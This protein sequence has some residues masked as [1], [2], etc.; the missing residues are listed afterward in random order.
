M[1]QLF[2]IATISPG[3]LQPSIA[4]AT[5]RAGELALLDFEYI[6]DPHTVAK[7]VQHLTGAF[8]IKLSGAS[9]KAL[10]WLVTGAPERLKTV[11][12]TSD[13]PQD[14]RDPVRLLREKGITTLLEAR[15][16]EEARNGEAIGVDGIIAKGHE[17]GGR[18]AD[19]T[20]FVL[21]QRF[22]AEVSL[23]VWAHGGIGL[24]TG[25]ACAMAGAAGII[26]DVQ[27]ALTRESP[28]SEQV[29]ARIRSMDGSETL[30][31]GEQLGETYRVY[32]RPGN[33]AVKQLQ[34]I[35]A[36]LSNDPRSAQ[37]I[38]ADWRQ[39]VLELAGWESEQNALMLGQDAAFAAS[40]AKRFHTVGG[41]LRAM[42]DAIESHCH[43]ADRLRPLA[44]GAPLARSHGTRYP[45]LQGP[46]TRVSDVPEFGARVA[47]EGGLPFLA[48]ALMRGPEIKS[49]LERAKDR[50][51]S[52][53]WGVG[54]LGFVPPELRQEQLDVIRDYP[55]PFALIA[56]GRPDQ[57]RA[58]EQQGIT[59]YLH[60]PS[61]GLLQ[62]FV[63]QGARRFV[64]EGRECGGHVG[65]RTS[66]VLWNQMVDVLLDAPELAAEP[67]SFHVVFA[68]GIHDA[69]SAAMVSVIAAPLAERGVRIGA[70]LGT[71]YLFTE[72]AVA[73][74]AIMKTFQ[75]QARQCHRT[76]LLETGPGHSTRCVDTPYA[77]AFTEE[78]KRLST[79]G[80][81]ADEVRMA[82][83][84]L[85]LGRLRIA[86]KGLT[87]HPGFAQ[88]G[89]GPK[90]IE[91]GENEQV[92]Q[93]MY[94][95][96][97][98]AALRQEVCTIQE[99]HRSVAV[100][101]SNKLQGLADR[102]WQAP[103]AVRRAE[104][105][106]SIAIIGMSCLL[107][108]APDLLTYWD[109]ILHKVD[110][111]G[112]I[113]KGRW[114]WELYFDSDPKAKDKI[115][116]KWGGF[117]EDVAFD[118]T[119]Y[120]MPPASLRS[121]EPSQLLTLEVVRAGLEDAG[122]LE[123]SFPRDRTSIILGAGGGAADLGLG[124]GARSFMP[125]LENLPEFR[126]RSGEIIER[127]GGRLPE[128][129]EDSFAGIL[130]NV[131]AGRVAN[132]FDLGGS[133]Y[134]VDAACASSLAA[135]SLALKE[136]DGHTSDMVIVGG[137]DT[138]QNPFTYLCFSKTHALSP[139]G[140]C[141]TFD[142]SAD[143]IAISEGIAVM[144][145]KRLEDAERDGDRIYAV[146]K[147]AGSSSDG[148][149][150][151]LTAPRPEGQARALTRAYAKAGISPSAVGLIEAHGT[152]TV[153]GD[154]AEVQALTQVFSQAGARRQGCAVGS[155]KSMIGH[156]KCTAG[157][158][159]MIKAAMAL[160]HKVLPATLGVQKPNPRARFAESPFFV[161]TETRPWL[162]SPD[163]QPRRAGVSA[164][165]F[166]GT[167]FHV[168]MEE[169]TGDP[170]ASIPTPCRQW[171][172]ELLVWRGDSREAL[173]AGIEVWEKA[174]TTQAQP[175]LRDLA[176]TAWKQAEDV[177]VGNRPRLQLAIVASSV[178]DLKQKLAL[179]RQ[180]LA[181]PETVRINDP[182]GIYYS[183]Q[184]L[185]SEGRLAFMFPGQG[186]QYPGMLEDLLLIFPETRRVFEQAVRVLEG[187]LSEPLSDYVFPPPAFSREEEQ[188]RQK[189]LTQT[190]I[191]QPALGAVSLAMLGLLQELGLQPHMVAGH[192]YGEYVALAAAGVFSAE[193]LIALSE[194][195]GRF[196]VE[197]AGAE[198]GVMAAVEA[199]AGSVTEVLKNF[200]DVCLAN[201]NAPMQSVISGS[202]AAVERVVKHLASQGTTARMIPVACAF[203]SPIVGPA[204]AR[205]GQFLATVEVAEPA[206][207]V[208]SNTT[209]APYPKEPQAVA[210]RLVEHLVRPVEF[211]REI[212]AMYEAGARVFVE[213]GPRGVLTGLVDK[214][215][216]DR[217]KLAV[218]SN[219]SGRPGLTQL[220]HLIAQLAAHGFSPK[221][222]RLFRDRSNRRLDLAS[223]QRESAEKPLAPS[224]WMVNGARATPLNGAA[225]A[226][227]PEIKQTPPASQPAASVS[228]P[229]SN[230]VPFSMPLVQQKTVDPK[231][232][233]DFTMKTPTPSNPMAA[234]EPDSV[235]QVMTQFQ[236]VMTQFLDTQKTVML[237]YLGS[238]TGTAAVAPS[239]SAPATRP[240]EALPAAADLPWTAPRV[241]NPPA[242][243]PSAPAL[244]VPT[245]VGTESPLPPSG[246]NK[247]ELTAQ[248][249]AIVSERTGYPPEMLNLNL[250]LEAD[251]GIDSIKRVEILG[252][253]AATG[254]A[255]EGLM[256]K[257]SGIRT[258]QGII[259]CVAESVGTGPAEPATLRATEQ[260]QPPA[261]AGPDRVELTAQLVAIVSER[262]GYPAEMLNLNLDLEADLGIDSIKRVEILGT[263]QQTSTSL[264]LVEGLME[265]LSGVRTLQG[266]IDLVIESSAN[267]VAPP[268]GEPAQPAAVAPPSPG[269]TDEEEQIQR[270]TLRAVEAPFSGRSVA[271]AKD[272]PILIAGG[273]AVAQALARELTVHGYR[274]ATVRQE[275]RVQ[276]LEP[277]SYTADLG[278]AESVTQ[279]IEL[280]SQQ[281]G[282]LGTLVH[283]QAL[284][285]EAW[286]AQDEQVWRQQLRL[287]VKSLYH[288]AK[289]AGKHL[290][291]GAADSGASVIAVTG[292]GGTFLSDLAPDASAKSPDHGAIA[293]L[294]KTL[295]QEWPEVRIKAVDFDLE[296][297]CD[298]LAHRLF[299]ELHSADEAVEIGYDQGRRVTLVPVQ[300][301]LSPQTPAAL[302]L[303]S[304]AVVLIT[305]GARGITARAAGRLAELYQP[306]LVLAGRSPLPQPEEA[307]ETAGITKT[308]ELK[309]ALMD[310]MRACGETVTPALVERAYA[311]LTAEREVRAN[312]A[313]LRQLGAQVHYYAVD[314]RDAEAFGGL[315]DRIYDSFGRLDGVIHGAGVIEDKLLQDKT[316]DSFD[317]VFDTKVDSAF[318]L[319]RKLRP[320]Q[321]KFLVF[322][323]SV[324]G[325]FGNR[326]QGDYAAANEVLNKLALTLDRAWPCRVVAINWGPWDTE[327]MVSAEVRKRF[328]ERGVQLISPAIGLRRLEEEISHGR[329]GEA[330]VVIG[331]AGWQPAREREVSRTSRPLLGQAILS[332]GEHVIEVVRDFDPARDLYLKDHQ[333]DG[334]P[335][336]PLAVATELIAE[337]VEHGWPELQV[338]A[339]RGLRLLHGVVLETG[340]KTLRVVARLQSPA[341]ASSTSVDVEVSGVGPSHRIHYR[342]TVDLV[343]RL[344]E[345]PPLNVPP[346]TDAQ[347]F[348][349]NTAELYR[350]W[351]FHGPMFQGIR[352]VDLVSA[353]GI[354]ASLA[355]SPPQGWIAG[356]PEGQWLIDPL[357]F[358]SALQLLVLWA[359]E[360]WDMT[361]L[362]S[363]FKSYRRFGSL[364][365][366]KIR[367]E[368][369]IRPETAGPAIHADIYF[370]DENTG[371]VL[372]VLEDMQGTCSKSLNRLAGREIALAVG[373]AS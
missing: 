166:G 72:E 10:E 143:G 355:T 29:K 114:D 216:G 68:A 89:T 230:G 319:S 234:V 149:D 224:V 33:P 353:G 342:A 154:G 112:E 302:S 333:L 97:Q 148:K 214:I 358:D 334:Q 75:E 340:T 13:N 210:E 50:M 243:A 345:A 282:P 74:G 47:E 215:L 297:N 212:E 62:M 362:P 23:P 315:I 239:L 257:L 138:M 130:T 270:F 142:E 183:Q 87:R 65:P 188:A 93:G 357:M 348:S 258:L 187:K 172:D 176:Y 118:P 231:P 178:D 139:R 60:V 227:R 119:R 323:S 271:P 12:L 160:H 102:A 5:Q 229:H 66:F 134:T 184:L 137:I 289:A 162:Q 223:L 21:L 17:A 175:L 41:V 152:G 208:F 100:A 207:P 141:R 56:G 78:K 197:G 246:P 298:I 228:V 45:I 132:R 95:I 293:G 168:V 19:E 303:D 191:A 158:A 329:R 284:N 83:E 344:P 269:R 259:D 279:L 115:Y 167:N 94:M 179:A 131:A 328:A 301:P 38:L 260:P 9:P 35:E 311:R 296:E 51:G 2:R 64:F 28:L 252:T 304:S 326:G 330:E 268:A 145:F 332:R 18:V 136:L 221:L 337:T 250:D 354:Q 79:S 349:M 195:R 122:Y 217:P 267:P 125:A 155:V 151:G 103:A 321:L 46:M 189:A 310:Q 182:R 84:S 128:W 242:V 6:R 366:S 181:Q 164:F 290:R 71:A 251:L 170:S 294:M 147:G 351:L 283:L 52:M 202:K 101:G 185:A 58:L 86:S 165:G 110:A 285:G 368:M 92:A 265:K 235:P 37:E 146:I 240:A 249:L 200:E 127:L 53:P 320:E 150:R 264:G 364:S 192:S 248:L 20:T 73:S 341:S 255:V 91:L 309:A 288:L 186:S 25:P 169:Y 218:A 55:P 238:E 120:G 324:A 27:L 307:A 61:P 314:V 153:A 99:L 339:V 356:A 173:L 96:G 98:V 135:V 69:L 291:H 198:P 226:A 211:V 39:A 26:L 261:A 336:L 49:L 1:P 15:C 40:M 350:R 338:A 48:L 359:R 347:A 203:H 8:G 4:L 105:S 325:R 219:Q 32:F 140:R 14:L 263:F 7:A 371:R 361:A 276:E 163:G 204:Q 88:E 59:T 213:V 144:V 275:A 30:V 370:S 247:E 190:N 286:R 241:D 209:A 312:L 322:F 306:T 24:H 174:L 244:S 80:L 42:R 372:S 352:R 343:R 129:T 256:E 82:L 22:R 67:E 159:G 177:P 124:Y 180:S 157:A 193:T 111:V 262:T 90:L 117:L 70:L 373:N 76:V 277:G 335:V 360:H 292:M 313:A 31:L 126:G 108:K 206:I 199:D 274:V 3:L 367:C 278:S 295:A 316:A 109:N 299:A 317:R 346:L 327:G 194:A 363:G 253:F 233:T 113:P 280:L 201:A 237:A 287:G 273:H 245:P 272:R 54:I 225:K 104:S 281:E 232:V 116:S 77:A 106:S 156:T 308:R 300:A 107:P 11:I 318:V 369:R 171:S 36:R 123:R 365:T 81:P 236:Q 331:G 57:A 34:A 222:D 161:N 254:I 133:N 305:G 205:L 16:L 85:N 63:Q 266:I 220:L 43:A 121:I 196:I 44:E